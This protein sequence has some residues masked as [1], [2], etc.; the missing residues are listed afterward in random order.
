MTA[1]WDFKGEYW[2]LQDSGRG[3]P[4]YHVMP[5]GQKA[6][7]IRSA[8]GNVDSFI[9]SSSFHP[10]GANVLIL[11]GSVRFLKASVG[12]ATWN[13]LGTR[14]GGEVVSADSY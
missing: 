10:G 5:P 4:Y 3:G 13:A 8:F 7:A 9:G 6:C 11:D 1:L 2:T 14:S 12:L